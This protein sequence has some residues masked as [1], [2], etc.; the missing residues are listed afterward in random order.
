MKKTI[1]AN[2]FTLIEM[3]VAISI[4]LLMLGG[5][6]ASYIRFQERRIV[7]T[8]G[9][10]LMDFIRLA[11][12][13][14]AVR[15]VP[16]ASAVCNQTDPNRRLVGYRARKA[17]GSTTV[18]IYALCGSSIPG[19]QNSSVSYTHIIPSGITIS[20][21][22][23]WQYDFYT[24]QETPSVS[25]SSITLSSSGETYTITVTAAGGI[26]GQ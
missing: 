8:Q 9:Q 17:S 5:G 19:S 21:T 22:S 2:G 14:A 20:P 23:L 10:E 13:K 3:L 7:I 11:Q 18:N 25:P 1:R 4:M 26:S 15:E 6:I 16:P 12:Q 24:L